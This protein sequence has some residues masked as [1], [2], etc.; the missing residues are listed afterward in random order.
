MGAV[1]T[2]L[3]EQARSIFDE[4]GYTVSR[5]GSE[6]RA[7]YKWRTVTVSVLEPDEMP[8]ETGELRCFVTRD[9]DVGRLYTRLRGM[10]LSYEWALIGV[11]DDGEYEVFPAEATPTF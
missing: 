5:T 1:T 3:G 9:G 2:S 6:I 11:Q 4:L 7:E 10:D 8:P